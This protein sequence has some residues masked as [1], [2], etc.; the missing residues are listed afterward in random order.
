MLILQKMLSEPV[1]MGVFLDRHMDSRYTIDLIKTMAED[2]YAVIKAIEGTLG[3]IAR[4]VEDACETIKSGGSVI[5]IGAGTSGRLGVLDAVEVPP[6]FGVARDVFKAIIAGGEKALTEAVEGAEDDEEAGRKAISNI[7]DK[8]LLIGISASGTTPYTISAL[9]EGKRLG[10]RCWLI[11]MKE[12]DYDFLEGIIM[13]PVG[14]EIIEGSTR[15]KAG[16]ATKIVL[17][18]I[19]TATMIKLGR[20]YKGLMIDVIPSNKKLRKRA[21]SI[22]QRIVGCEEEK[23]E[24]LFQKA[25]GNTR[26]AIVMGVKDTGYEEALSLLEQAEYDLHKIIE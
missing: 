7:R 19:S 15:L 22:V 20:V 24:E 16:T 6:T 8:D 21:I 9:K 3:T 2:N 18:M 4:L 23:A 26:V 17:N 5:Y 12:V 1:V 14:P 25:R 10:A 11:T 13:L